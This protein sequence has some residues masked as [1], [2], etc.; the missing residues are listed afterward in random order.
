MQDRIVEIIHV[1]FQQT[2]DVADIYAEQRRITAQLLSAGYD[3]SEVRSV[4]SWLQR[5]NLTDRVRSADKVK[6]GSFKPAQVTDGDNRLYIS[7][8]AYEMLHRLGNNGVVDHRLHNDILDLAMGLPIEEI[9][10]KTVESL[11]TMILLMRYHNDDERHFLAGPDEE[12]EGL[13]N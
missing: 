10:V 2:L 3:K 5:M 9:S 1:I 12:N 7:P 11:A 8:E 6:A 4:F 13:L